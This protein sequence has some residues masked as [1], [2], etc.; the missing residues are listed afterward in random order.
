MEIITKKRSNKNIDFW[1]VSATQDKRIEKNAKNLVT[2]PLHM[3]I[4]AIIQT[5]SWGENVFLVF[6]LNDVYDNVYC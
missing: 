1:P 6:Y 4:N 2:L 3:H 5:T